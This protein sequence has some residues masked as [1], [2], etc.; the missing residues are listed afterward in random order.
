MNTVLHTHWESRFDAV[1]KTEE[2]FARL[3]EIGAEAVAITDH[4]SLAAIP[5]AYDK[6][7]VWTD[8]NGKQKTIKI[9]YGV[10]AYLRT[11]ENRISHL[12]VMAKDEIGKHCV[13]K[14][15]HDANQLIK[16]GETQIPVVTLDI[17]TKYFGY[18]SC[19]QDH[20]IFTTACVS[21]MPAIAL[22]SNELIEH[23]IEKIKRKIENG[24]EKGTLTNPENNDLSNLCLKQETLCKQENE[25]KEQK[26]GLQKIS[27]KKTTG[28]ENR[29]EKYRQ[30]NDEDKVDELT[31][32]I[33]NIKNA[34]ETALKELVPINAKLAEYKLEIAEL[35]KKINA[36]SKSNTAY[37][38]FA[39]KINELEA[40]KRTADELY[41]FAKSEVVTLCKTVGKNNLF[42]ELQYHGLEMEKQVY[43]KLAKIARELDLPV[44]AAND[45]H[46]ASKTKADLNA[47]SV[48]RF[49]R[50]GK[51]DEESAAEM[52]DAD[53]EDAK[54]SEMLEGSEEEI[55]ESPNELEDN[56]YFKSA[57]AEMYIKD[58]RELYK[59]L[60]QILPKDIVKEAIDNTSI[61]GEMCNY[62]PKKEEHYPVFD[63]NADPKAT[64]RKLAYDGIEW[65]FPKRCGWT[66][67]YQKRMERELDVICNMGYADYHLITRDFITY[68]QI[69]GNVP[70]EHVNEAPLSIEEAKKWI[71]DN[72]WDVGIGIGPGR[73]SAAGSLVCYLIGITG[74][75]PLKY[76]LLFERER[77]CAH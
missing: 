43:P 53:D 28:L 48:A 29:L 55:P 63:K 49:L 22:R 39:K 35:N 75:D 60:I 72:G 36:M 26:K 25:L 76:N 11:D 23:E 46:M 10:E 40:E 7:P 3:K 47:R 56:E 77:E 59:A 15:M 33:K 31:E 34:S 27:T 71:D 73:G 42:I 44:V 30:I 51:I 21:G 19:G 18:G 20:A 32:Q 5:D 1:P 6:Q 67:I 65:R 69:L 58:N 4:G 37:Q 8:E 9:I 38:E 57:G 41:R 12:I 45:A 61:I 66:D 68:A 70:H 16:N 74:I 14:M 17:L 54:D 52:A 2:M 50:F 13:D 64:L 62:S 24:L